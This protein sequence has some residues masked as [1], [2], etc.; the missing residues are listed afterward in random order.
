VS[1]DPF[2]DVRERL[3]KI[4]PG[5]WDYRSEG[6][7]SWV[8]PHGAYSEHHDDNR[9]IAHAPEDIGRLLAE[10]DWLRDVIRACI[11]DA[12]GQEA[13]RDRKMLEL[14]KGQVQLLARALAAPSTETDS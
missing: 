12:E 6:S 5:P 14:T 7:M 11:G 4:T 1:A 10:Y 9:F 8:W 3:A 13:V 2:K